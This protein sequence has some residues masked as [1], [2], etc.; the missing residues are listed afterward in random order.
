MDLNFK[1]NRRV[2]YSMKCD[3]YAI[4]V[5]HVVFNQGRFWKKIL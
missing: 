5:A 1:H 2:F 3:D 4:C